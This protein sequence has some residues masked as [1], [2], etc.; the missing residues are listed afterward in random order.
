MSPALT[1][2]T[3][4]LLCMPCEHSCV[5]MCT[6]TGTVYAAA[7]RRAT[8][9]WS[10]QA[11]DV[12]VCVSVCVL[13]PNHWKDRWIWT[14]EFLLS[15]CSH[16]N[17]TAVNKQPAHAAVKCESTPC[18]AVNISLLLSRRGWRHQCGEEKTLHHPDIIRTTQLTCLARLTEKL[19]KPVNLSQSNDEPAPLVPAKQGLQ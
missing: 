16:V 19:Q 14:N 12:C 6:C 11:V 7:S 13:Q 18:S 15:C 5:R 8:E 4:S 1:A 17:I 10:V 3:I 9:S 2:C